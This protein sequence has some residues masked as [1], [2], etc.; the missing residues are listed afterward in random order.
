[1]PMPRQY[2]YQLFIFKQQIPKFSQDTLLIGGVLLCPILLYFQ[3]LKVDGVL[4]QT[5]RKM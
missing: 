1:M 3:I 5:L 4:L 2:I